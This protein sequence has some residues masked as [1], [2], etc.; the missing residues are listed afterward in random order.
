[1]AHI[2]EDPGMVHSIDNPLI[3]SNRALNDQ[4]YMEKMCEQPQLWGD[5]ASNKGTG[6]GHRNIHPQIEYINRVPTTVRGNDLQTNFGEHY[7]SWL[8][9]LANW[10]IET[11]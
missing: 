1:M 11:K 6:F 8:K 10:S 9:Y 7:G 3:Y 2:R 5:M 4:V